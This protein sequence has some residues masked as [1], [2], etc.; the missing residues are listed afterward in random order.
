MPWVLASAILLG[1][2]GERGVREREISV[3]RYVFGAFGGA[4]V[5]VRD[6]CASG[7]AERI[8]VTR[9][10]WA[11]AASFASLGLYLPHQLRIAC[12]ER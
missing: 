7:R 9:R 8:E 12:D 1:C 10:F 3:H 5:D 4:S 11:Y 6:V 2:A